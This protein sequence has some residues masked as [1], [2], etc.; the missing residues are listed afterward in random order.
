MRSMNTRLYHISSGAAAQQMSCCR[1]LSYKTRHFSAPHFPVLR[2]P[3]LWGRYC[4]VLVSLFCFEKLRES[5]QGTKKDVT[6]CPLFEV[7]VRFSTDAVKCKQRCTRC[8]IMYPFLVTRSLRLQTPNQRRH[9]N[10]ACVI[11]ASLPT[12]DQTNGAI[13]P[14]WI[15]LVS[16]FTM[17]K[18]CIIPIYFSSI[19]RVPSSSTRPY[20]RRVT[21]SAPPTPNTIPFHPIPST[22]HSHC[23]PILSPH[24]VIFLISSHPT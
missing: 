2:F 13:T 23:H 21:T 3:P 10:V 15:F 8:S 17:E 19:S 6:S 4:C 11:N 12:D 16:F 5:T 1:D 9:E 14:I 20:H 18:S 24:L 22:P 7:Q